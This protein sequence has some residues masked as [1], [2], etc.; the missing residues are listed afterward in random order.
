M[1]KRKQRLDRIAA[2]AQ[3]YLAAK[4]AA[5]LLSVKLTADPSYGWSQ[6]WEP[7][8]GAAFSANLEATYIIRIYAE[9]EAGLR[10]Y[11]KTRL[12]HK[13]H[14]SML[15]LVCHAIPNEYFSQDCVE[16]ADDVR[17]YRN[18]LVHDMEEDPPANMVTV[19]VM[20][21]KKHL[22]AYFSRLDARWL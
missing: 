14:P 3:E 4:T 7:K 16:N 8:A 22:C 5:S 12:G 6:R 10:D 11:W 18:F 15:D 13:T 17:E 1:N 9:F 2:V 21:A 19:T 20:E